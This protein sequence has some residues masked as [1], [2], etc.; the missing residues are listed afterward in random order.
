MTRT[1]SAHHRARRPGPAVVRATTRYGQNHPQLIRA[2]SELAEV[3]ENIQA[4]IGR[5]ISNLRAQKNVADQRLASI[6]GSL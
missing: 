2:K 6:S 4:E 1:G 5:V 3:Q